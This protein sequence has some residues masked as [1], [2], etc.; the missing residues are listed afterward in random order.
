[1]GSSRGSF[2]EEVPGERKER[3]RKIKQN[4]EGR[5]YAFAERERDNGILPQPGALPEH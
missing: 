1:M 2:W 4:T 3:P 5:I